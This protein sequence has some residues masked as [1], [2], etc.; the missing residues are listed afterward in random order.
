VN[1]S[2]R[3][4]FIKHYLFS[5]SRCLIRV[6]G[7]DISLQDERGVVRASTSDPQNLLHRLL[8]RSF[9]DEPLLTE[10]DWYGDTVFNRLQM[11]RFLSQWKI[12]ANHSKT[13]EEAKVVEDVR[14]LA[15][16]CEGAVHLYLKIVGD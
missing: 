1:V 14:A 8:E 12:L 2:F 11:P 16:E 4:A 5:T 15:T 7:F 13:P 6:M 3:L 10:I 9:A